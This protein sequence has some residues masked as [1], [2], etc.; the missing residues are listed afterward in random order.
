[1]FG[2]EIKSLAKLPDEQFNNLLERGLL[3]GKYDCTARDRMIATADLTNH[4]LEIL[5]IYGIKSDFSYNSWTPEQLK[6]ILTLPAK[7]RIKEL[8]K[9]NPNHPTKTS[10]GSPEKLLDRDEIIKFA[11]LPELK[12]SK[13]QALLAIKQSKTAELSTRLLGL[14]ILKIQTL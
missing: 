4:D 12:I 11:E 13:I 14:R 7:Y 2:S 10:F 6:K 8:E 9:I 1:M 3:S 5:D